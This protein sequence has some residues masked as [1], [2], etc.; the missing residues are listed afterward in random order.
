MAEPRPLADD[1]PIDRAWKIGRRIY[2]RCGYASS[3]NAQLREVGAKW[4]RD[5]RALWV[6]TGKAANVLPLIRAQ[7]ERVAAI[8]A[9]KE[10]SRWVAIPYDATEIRD[11]AKASGAIW[12]TTSKRWSMPTDESYTSI[13]TWVQQWTEARDAVRAAECAAQ[14]E[15]ER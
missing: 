14:R 11:A 9:I 4:D 15:A 3:L 13:T 8:T 7:D 12:D 10:A 5:V 2:I 1:I 6:G